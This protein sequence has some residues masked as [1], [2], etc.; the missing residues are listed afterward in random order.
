MVSI[1]DFY[2][3]QKRPQKRASILSLE[4]LRM[5]Q[6]LMTWYPYMKNYI[7]IHHMGIRI[8]TNISMISVCQFAKIMGLFVISLLI[9]S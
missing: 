9:L 8:F 6:T 1:I 4:I 2:V 5:E 7:L 3:L